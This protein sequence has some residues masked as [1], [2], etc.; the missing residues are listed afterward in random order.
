M[1]EIL[2]CIFYDLQTVVS[3]FIEE[4]S[5]L[6]LLR[7]P[8]ILEAAQCGDS[9]PPLAALKHYGSVQ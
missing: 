4:I 2:Q 7:F 3:V 9:F 8:W 1:F 6:Q 5:C